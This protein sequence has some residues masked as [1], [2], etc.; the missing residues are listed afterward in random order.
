MICKCG[1][2]P[3]AHERTKH[4]WVRL[5]PPVEIARWAVEWS[6]TPGYT[7]IGNGARHSHP[8]EPRS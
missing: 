3:Q 5:I 1:A 6:G 4:C 2:Q 7:R 8:M